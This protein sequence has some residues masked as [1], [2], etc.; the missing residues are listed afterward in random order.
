LLKNCFFGTH[1]LGNIFKDYTQSHL[2]SELCID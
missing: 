1:S 2:K